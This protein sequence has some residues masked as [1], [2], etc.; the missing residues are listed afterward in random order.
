M[1]ILCKQ[2]SEKVKYG[3]E[4][5]HWLDLAGGEYISGVNSISSE[6]VGSS[7]SDLSLTTIGIYDGV[8]TKSKVLF[9]VESGTAPNT[10]RI[11]VAVTTSAG[12]KF[13]GD[14]V[15]MVKDT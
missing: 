15:L 5:G 1:A 8:G 4:M 9:W 11:E 13:E 12:Q 7:T 10:Y 14:G 2:P 3:M 6:Q